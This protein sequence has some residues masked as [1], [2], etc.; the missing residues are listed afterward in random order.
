MVSILFTPAL[1]KPL[2]I[3]LFIA[4]LGFAQ[5]QSKMVGWSKAPAGSKRSTSA[6]IRPSDQ[7]DGVEIEDIIVEGKPVKVGQSFVAGD[8]WIQTLTFRVKNVSEQQ[9]NAVQITVILPEMST[10][11][12]E[13]VFCYGCFKSGREKGIVPGEEVELKMPGGKYYAWVRDKITAQGY[14]SRIGKAHIR[15]IFVTL[16]DGTKLLSGCVKTRDPKNACPRTAP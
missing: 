1:A 3:L 16:P 10:G 13:I 4:A 14:I 11:G 15:D 7:I 2:A 8:D 12:P 5:D 9:F 6:Y